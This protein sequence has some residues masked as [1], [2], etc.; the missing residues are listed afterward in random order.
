MLGLPQTPHLRPPL[1]GPKRFREGWGQDLSLRVLHGLAFP[2]VCGLST[3]LP[4]VPHLA[5]G[6]FLGLRE[7][8]PS[9]YHKDTA[10]GRG[11]GQLINAADEVFGAEEAI[12]ACKPLG[13][14]C[15]CLP[16]KRVHVTL[17]LPLTRAVQSVRAQCDFSTLIVMPLALPG[18][19]A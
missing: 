12:V 8:W 5:C 11:F 9:V 13:P 1:T 10:S 18:E 15:P 4:H 3:G 6:V 7:P 14:P 16:S 19:H 17:K 2:A